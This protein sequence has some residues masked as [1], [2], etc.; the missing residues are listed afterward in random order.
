MGVQRQELG[1]RPGE[2]A[3]PRPG[4]SRRARAAAGA[5]RRRPP[6]STRPRPAS[7]TTTSTSWSATACWRRSKARRLQQGAGRLDCDQRPPSRRSPAASASSPRSTIKDKGAKDGKT[8]WSRRSSTAWTYSLEPLSET[9]Q[10]RRVHGPARQ[11]RPDAGPVPVSPVAGL[12]REGLRRRLQPRRHRAVLPAGAEQE[13][14]GLRQAARRLR[15]A[16]DRARGHPGQ[17]VLRSTTTG[18]H[19]KGQLL[20]FEVLVDPRGGPLRGLPARTTR[21]SMAGCCRTASSALRR[22]DLRRRLERP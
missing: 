5:D 11:R 6:S 19:V 21:R 16:P 14:A 10:G 20:G 9:E 7:P 22:Q 1:D 3:Q 15:G 8:S 2:A 4:P 12:R 18:R 13:Q 17:V